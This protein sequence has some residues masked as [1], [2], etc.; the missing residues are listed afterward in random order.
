M[1]NEGSPVLA[2]AGNRI[3]APDRETPRFPPTNVGLVTDRVGA[4]L[5]GLRPRCV[6]GSAASGAD[7]I[8]LS[9]ADRRS[10]PS[11]VVL[12]LPLDRFREISV[13]DQGG[14]WLEIFD[15]LV[16]R[17][18]SSVVEI[19]IADRSDDQEWELKGNGMIIDAAQSQAADRPIAALVVADLGVESIS[20]RFWDQAV[21][22]G[23]SVH[24]I[25]PIVENG[26]NL[27]DQL[28]S[29]G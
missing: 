25:S 24:V 11:H 16:G 23:W 12:P 15:R 29:G 14:Q 4:L 27:P 5:D 1:F 28:L 26:F 9:E 2:F 3:D 6:V 21:A 17:P 7:L 10:I 20:T 19:I 18:G 22:L 8:V 13:A